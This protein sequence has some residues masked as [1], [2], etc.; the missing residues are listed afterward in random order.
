M[1]VGFCP[2]KER[3][4]SSRCKHQLLNV[5][6]WVLQQPDSANEL[7]ELVCHSE[8]R[9]QTRNGL[10]AYNKAGQWPLRGWLFILLIISSSPLIVF[11]LVTDR[12][13]LSGSQIYLKNVAEHRWIQVCGSRCFRQKCRCSRIKLIFSCFCCPLP[14]TKVQ[15]KLSNI[16]THIPDTSQGKININISSHFI[17]ACPWN[18]L[19]RALILVY[20]FLC[21]FELNHSGLT[22]NNDLETFRTRTSLASCKYLAVFWR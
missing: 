10:L 15:W 9:L 3:I 7:S 2:M 20:T 16:P 4:G 14:L 12:C 13:Q 18:R 6:P 22:N 5:N 8:R 21:S 11:P 17:I 19:T 1:T